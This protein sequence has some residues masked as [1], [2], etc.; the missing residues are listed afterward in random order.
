[1][2]AC[3]DNGGVTAECV[4]VKGC[5]AEGRMGRNQRGPGIQS[6]VSSVEL[7]GNVARTCKIY[8]IH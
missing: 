1:M 3:G 8:V 2:V 4:G 5:A 7:E 6:D